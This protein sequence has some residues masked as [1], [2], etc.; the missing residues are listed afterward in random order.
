MY[1]DFIKAF[2]NAKVLGLTATPYRLDQA[3]NGPQLTFL[4][5]STPAI[6]DKV[7]YYVQNDVL[8]NAGFLAQ[9]EYYNFDVIDRSKL[10][11][12]SSG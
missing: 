8:F 6:F 2:P 7:L 4:T 11:V 3:S 12:N 5:R 10:E 1:I 9:L